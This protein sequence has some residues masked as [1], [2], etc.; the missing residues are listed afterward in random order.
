MALTSCAMR[1]CHRR[2]PSGSPAAIEA[3]SRSRAARSPRRTFTITD[4]PAMAAWVA[5]TWRLNESPAS[6]PVSAASGASSSA[7]DSGV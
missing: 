3:T 7:S 6:S 1:D 5:G 2:S 4:M